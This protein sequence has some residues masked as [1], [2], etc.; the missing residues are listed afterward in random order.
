MSLKSQVATLVAQGFDPVQISQELGV[1]KAYISQLPQDSEYQS[2][3]AALRNSAAVAGHSVR[4]KIDQHYD[5]LELSL[6][7]TLDEHKDRIIPAMISKPA[8]LVAFMKTLNGAKRRGIGESAPVQ[9]ATKTLV[10]ILLPAFLIPTAMPQV[11][12]NTENEVIEV[13][14]VPLINMGSGTLRA[15][16]L[17]AQ[18]PRLESPIEPDT[19]SAANSAML[20]KRRLE[21]A[22][23][24]LEMDEENMD[25]STMNDFEPD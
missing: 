10:P 16:S 11:Q 18:T 9:D 20:H 15:R 12:H 23:R 19:E 6:L 22:M 13:D 14:G 4:V 17:V 5:S 3:L 7:E 2:I 25:F 21:L 24:D 8:T 1:S